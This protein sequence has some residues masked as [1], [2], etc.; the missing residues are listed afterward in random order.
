[1]DLSSVF[2]GIK[3]TPTLPFLKSRHA[4]L[5]NMIQ[6]SQVAFGDKISINPHLTGYR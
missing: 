1:M 4:A 2:L 3:P 5:Q 6:T